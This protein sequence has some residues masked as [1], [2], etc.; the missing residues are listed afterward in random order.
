MVALMTADS[1]PAA[2]RLDRATFSAA[3]PSQRHALTS[4][5]MCSQRLHPADIDLVRRVRERDLADAR[6]QFAPFLTMTGILFA[7]F[8]LSLNQEMLPMLIITGAG[9]L[10]S[11]YGAWHTLRSMSKTSR[12]LGRFDARTIDQDED[13]TMQ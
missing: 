13:P 11:L 12:Q 6:A 9:M 7:M 10:V 2:S 8:A 4:D 3:S 5:W 1:L